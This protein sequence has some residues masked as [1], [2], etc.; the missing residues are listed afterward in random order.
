M[1]HRLAKVRAKAAEALMQSESLSFDQWLVIEALALAGSRS[2]EGR[3]M[4]E[5]QHATQVSGPT[6]TRVVDKLVM[7]AFLYREV[8]PA[9]RRKVRVHLSDRGADLY[10]RLADLLA[11]DES[12]WLGSEALDRESRENIARIT[13]TVEA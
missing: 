12:E 11:A 8:D 6:L 4:A 3:T 13:D 9:D 5:V 10:A 7:R 2:A 1:L